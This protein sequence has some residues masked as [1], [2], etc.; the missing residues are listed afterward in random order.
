MGRDQR[1]IAGRT[2]EQ[3]ALDALL[4]SPAWR[5]LLGSAGSGKTTLVAW[6]RDRAA[7]QRVPTL[8]V[9]PV[10]IES[11]IAFSSLSDLV[12]RIG[13]DCLGLLEDQHQRVFADLL[14]ATPVEDPSLVRS[15]FTAL[16]H[17]IAASGP[18]L[19]ILDDAHWID[20]QSAEVIAFACRRAWRDRP[21]LA[22]FRTK[23]QSLLLDAF[24]SDPSTQTIS[25]Q[26]LSAADLATIIGEEAPSLTP[27]L[28]IGLAAFANGNPLRAREIGRAARRGSEAFFARPD[29]EV[30]ANPL[31]SAAQLLE[32]DHLDVLYVAAQLLVSSV[33]TLNAVFSN[34]L[35]NDALTSAADAGHLVVVNQQIEF[36]HPLLGDAIA[37]LLA[38]QNRRDLHGRIAA[39]VDDQIERGRHLSLST[40]TFDQDTRIAIFIASTLAAAKGSLALALQLAYR[41]IEGVEAPDFG[42]AT[43]SARMF[44]DAQRWTANL[45][46][47]IDDP[48]AAA[49]RLFVLADRL[50]GSPLR[51][52]VE[53]DLANLQSW[54]TSLS[55]GIER[56]TDLLSSSDASP[57]EQAESGM[58]LAVLLVNTR[59]ADLAVEAG[60]RGRE[61]GAL[62]G[63][64]VEAESLSADTF[65][66][67][68]GGYGLDNEAITR[69]TSLEHLEN[70]LSVQCAPFSLAPFL[71]AWCDD[72]RMFDA[73]EKRRR[74][75]RQRGSTTAL[76]MG[77]PF[78]VHMLLR[79]GRTPEARALVQFAVDSAEFEN[80][81]T[82]SCSQL[83][84]GRLFAHLGMWQEAEN[85]LK[86]ADDIFERIEFRQGI[87]ESASVRVGMLAATADATAVLKFGTKWLRRID[88]FAMTEPMLIPGILDLIEAASS[89]DSSVMADLQARLVSAVDGDRHDIAS[90]RLWAESLR[91]SANRED[92]AR[93]VSLFEE[94]TNDWIQ[95]GRLFWGA[96]ASLAW[97]R[98]CRREGARRAAGDHFERALATFEAAEAHGWCDVTSADIARLGRSAT[99][100][101]GALSTV[102][103][104]VARHACAGASNKEIA[105]LMFVSDKTVES[106]LSSVY[107][108]L[109]I[110]RRT[111]LSAKLL[112]DNG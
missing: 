106:H 69:A 107:R 13:A 78:E 22:A 89:H 32:P 39:V 5:V 110:N 92:S 100:T 28:Q 60:R 48:Q 11:S 43:P 8:L 64:Q 3:E 77:I 23:E 35:V 30:E 51:S 75:F 70:W 93:V 84:E 112:G 98:H 74:V 71:F 50:A 73:G 97:G 83:A 36:E 37:S 9:R 21:A 10:E 72:D 61:A 38:P 87:I 27:A 102:E 94:L 62:A 96:R 101:K 63:G 4:T 49:R 67:F 18:C 58:Q 6:L 57:A 33:S 16:L 54:S 68:I 25:L 7:E 19:L 55:A 20:R 53:I 76:V 111:Q 41:A 47:R 91:T 31:M 66:R 29:I 26:Q 14:N 12:G 45:E 79:R 104:T 2:E 82:R 46:F 65:A 52:R 15:A 109:G 40:T 34:E 103:T 17:S 80:E 56:Y 81:L 95:S 86:T 1:R 108:K 59:T 88:E 44:I 99:T 42:E 105:Q 24:I 85:A 90:A